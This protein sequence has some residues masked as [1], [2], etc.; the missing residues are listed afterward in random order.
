[1]TAPLWSLAITRP[2][3]TARART[4]V[5][6]LA[7]A[8]GVTADDRL[9]LAVDLSHRLRDVLA[10][11][12]AA[13][14][15][16]GTE[17][18]SRLRVTVRTP[19]GRV[20]WAWRTAVSRDGNGGQATP[21]DLG[22]EGPLLD[23]ED[24]H[25][26]LAQALLAT[27]ADARVV[28]DMLDRHRHELGTTN[29][30]VLALHAELDS[31]NAARQQLLTAEQKAR[32]AAETA[33]S[34][35]TFLSSASAALSASL[36]H[37]EVLRHLVRLL[38]PERAATAHI[39]LPD[40][41]Q[42]LTPL[43]GDTSPHPGEL[44]PDHPAVRAARTG[45]PHHAEPTRGTGTGTGGRPDTALLALPLTAR[46]TTLGVLVL[47]PPA[48][49]FDPDEVVMLTELAR[50]AATAVDNAQ[51][52]EHERDTAEILQR[53]ML[54][55]LP[56]PRGLRLAARYLPATQGMNIGGDWYDAFTQPD[57]TLTT[58]IGDVTGHG[59]NAAVMMGQLRN[60]L[61]AYAVE[62]HS[63]G[64]LL[65]LLHTLLRR[66]EPD[67]YATA[68]VTQHRPGS[69]DVVWASAGHLPPLLRTP[70]GE[71]D[72]LQ[73]GVGAMLGLPLDQTVHDHH[74]AL[75]P[76]STL[77][78]YTD[79]LVERRADGVDP[80][81]EHMAT[82]LADVGPLAAA[83]PDTAAEALLTRMLPHCPREDDIC[84]LLCHA[85]APVSVPLRSLGETAALRVP[86][87][88]PDARLAATTSGGGA[89]E[90]AR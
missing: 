34:R 16:V 70:D 66:L 67:L 38:V 81:I 90:P 80:G 69:S 25:A 45:R 56:A 78:L 32:T 85:E 46:R 54:T 27:D 3:D 26:P 79:G 5:L 89:A 12:G 20:A 30:G 14:L 24:P 63:P 29:Q 4:A 52:Y 73:P 40:S 86:S 35:L 44:L 41:R 51:R 82:V 77:L 88:R 55:D 2:A 37:E 60:A 23:D 62:G 53:A 58:V 19:G 43:I 6:R 31:A 47:T 8:A 15:T 48:Q 36:D 64:A 57:G 7:T 10:V 83:D 18:G 28:L 33:R 17:P 71:V 21:A 76:G 39:W 50:R 65:T 9:R 87:P 68:V 11:D 61:R 59:L 42:T 74:L 72:I 75:T 22:A 84:I 1:M 13:C 49:H